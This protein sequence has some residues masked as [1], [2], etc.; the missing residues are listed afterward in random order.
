MDEGES[1]SQNSS[2]LDSE[3]AEEAREGL[4]RAVD[5]FE[6]AMHEGAE[7]MESLDEEKH[8]EAEELRAFLVEALLTLANFT[9]EED[10]RETLYRRAQLLGGEALEGMEVDEDKC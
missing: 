5:F 6:R 2:A 1:E 4:E 3:E 9:K 7:G 8:T 10:K